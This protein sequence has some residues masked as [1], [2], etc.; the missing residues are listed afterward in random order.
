MIMESSVYGSGDPWENGWINEEEDNAFS[1]GQGIGSG[2][3]VLTGSTVDTGM[4]DPSGGSAYPGTYYQVGNKLGDSI[5]TEQDVRL[6]VLGKLEERLLL[7]SYQSNRIVDTLSEHHALP[8]LNQEGVLVLLGLVAM[9]L[10]LAGT[11]D[12]VTVQMKSSNLPELPPDVVDLLL[13]STSTHR[14]SEAFMDPLTSHLAESHLDTGDDGTWDDGLNHAGRDIKSPNITDSLLG[15]DPTFSEP[16][17]QKNNSNSF[18]KPVEFINNLRDSFKP[19]VGSTALVNIKEV[20]EKEG[21][22]FK[23]INYVITHNLALGMNGPGGM[24]KVLRRY[25]DFVW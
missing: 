16:L 23:H 25:S 14:Q 7:T 15:N 22:V 13:D 18:A 3:G 2:S 6:K 12:Y 8:I 19:L 5:R 24:K 17:T 1:G 9:E 21:L 10:D 20:P 4:E 11:G